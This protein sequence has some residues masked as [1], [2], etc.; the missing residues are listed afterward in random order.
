MNAGLARHARGEAVRGAAGKLLGLDP[1]R[2]GAGRVDREI[3]AERQLLQAHEPRALAGSEPDPGLQ[4][5]LV[6]AGVGMPALLHGGDPE[7]CPA[8]RARAGRRRLQGGR[9]DEADLLHAE[10]CRRSCAHSTA[11][12]GHTGGQP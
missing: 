11:I 7:R 3:R 12:F 2:R 1:G 9:G 8:G 4:G 6:L 10:D 5:G